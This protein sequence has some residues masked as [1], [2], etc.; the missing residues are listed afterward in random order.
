MHSGTWWVVLM[1]TGLLACGADAPKTEIKQSPGA[2]DWRDDVIYQIVVDRFDNGDESNDTVDGIGVIPGDL[3]RHQGGDFAGVERRLD[4]L[5][6]LGATTLWLSPI[7]ENVMRMPGGDG[8][9]GYWASD[10]TRINPRFGTLD[11][12]RGLVDAAHARGMKVMLDVVTNH[13]GALFSYDIDGDGALSPGE[14]EP[15]YNATGY[16]VPILWQFPRPNLWR[17]TDKGVKP[18]ALGL[19]D[20]HLRGQ[21]ENFTDVEQMVLGDFPTGLRDLA[22]DQKTV[23]SGL[24]D[25][26][27]EWVRLT[28]VDGVRLD[29]A[30]HMRH[31]EWAAFCQG[32]RDRLAA[33]GKH[34]FMQLGEVFRPNARELASYTAPGEFDS[35]FD[36]TLKY[37]G[38]DQF[39][40]EGGS[41]TLAREALE[42]ARAVYPLTGQ[43]NGL[44]LSPW[45]A[46][47]VFA[48][49]HDMS[50]MR[51][52][53][54][55]ERAAVLALAL[56]F[57]VDG[58]PAI[59]Y[60]TEQ[61]MKGA[62]GHES[63]EVMWEAGFDEDGATFR[64]I[65]LL[66]RL[67]RE[68]KAL[69]RGEL[70]IRYAARGLA[71]A[72]EPEEEDGDAGIITSEAETMPKVQAGDAGILAYERSFESDR[73]LIV[74]NARPD[75]P[76]R[77]RMQTGF[78]PGI[79]LVDLLAHGIEI[80]VGS[81]GYIEI[82]VPRRSALVLAPLD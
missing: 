12:L 59:Y 26:Y 35:T 71:R 69:R 82:D 2:R 50:R 55:D 73:L 74:L 42:G 29:A 33:V 19:E 38:I 57:T 8:Y 77:A 4:Y 44:E 70:T 78:E 16:K 23:M 18:F 14:A 53:L 31:G 6:R 3:S 39:V 46:R 65:A 61:G 45:Q 27:V 79:H 72:E 17:N 52:R 56:L 80:E 41:A 9:H 64:A 32:L 21:I 15:P 75:K 28:D 24:I 7:V 58:L 62:G 47:V 51:G 22:T 68:H 40:L 49:N 1:A 20:F 60:G 76:S 10:F 54:D 25:T 5:E 66:A 81:G 43:E 30:P 63:R 37:D 48:D 11:E 67:R 34:N 13:S 36:F